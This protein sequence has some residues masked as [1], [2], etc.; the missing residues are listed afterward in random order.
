MF[1]SP[2]HIKDD[3]YLFKKLDFTSVAQNFIAL[4]KYLQIYFGKITFLSVTK[5]GLR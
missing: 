1:A 5:I 4:K 3:I 2:S